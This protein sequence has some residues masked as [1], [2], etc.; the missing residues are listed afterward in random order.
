MGAAPSPYRNLKLFYWRTEK[1]VND[2][3]DGL[4]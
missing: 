2:K 3:D 1:W 4:F